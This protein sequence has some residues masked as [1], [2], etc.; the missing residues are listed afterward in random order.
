M[1]LYLAEN[2]AY[3]EERRPGGR[4]AVLHDGFERLYA[5]LLTMQGDE[6]L[7]RAFASR[8]DLAGLNAAAFPGAQL[9]ASGFDLAGQ[10]GYELRSLYQAAQTYQLALDR[11]YALSPTI[12]AALQAGQGGFITPATVTWYFDRLVRASTQ[13]TRAWA[14]I[15]QRYQRFNRPELARSVARRAYTAGYLESVVMARM[16]L[17]VVDVVAVEDRAQ[18]RAIMEAAQGRS[19]VALSE[20]RTV[21]GQLSEART[22]FGLAPDYVPMPALDGADFRQSNAFE[23]VLRRA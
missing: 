19:R 11:F 9:E 10:A 6:A 14:E 20:L 8:F 21:F 12:W 13:K 23:A 5:E 3:A 1:G 4:P 7:T 22:V 2:F 18:I 16:M 15:A 17:Q